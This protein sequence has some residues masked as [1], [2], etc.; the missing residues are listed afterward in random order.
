MFN[1]GVATLWKTLPNY[2]FQSVQKQFLRPKNKKR[3]Q[4]LEIVLLSYH[5]AFC[6]LYLYIN[7][8]HNKLLFCITT[9]LH[10]FC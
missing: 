7:Y 10:R 5:F 2:H 6:I 3:T 1:L 8:I 9:C 4:Q